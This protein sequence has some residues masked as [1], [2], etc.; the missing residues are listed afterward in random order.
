MA[1]NFEQVLLELFRAFNS[2][3]IF[4]RLLEYMHRLS[5]SEDILVYKVHYRKHTTF[6]R[7]ILIIY[8]NNFPKPSNK[9]L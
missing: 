3:S 6:K 7:L 9:F 1:D 4:L 2:S 5:Q 8:Q